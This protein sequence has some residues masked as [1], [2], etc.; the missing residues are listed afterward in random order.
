MAPLKLRRIDLTANNAAAQITKL[1]DQFRYDSEVVSAAGKKLT[2]GVFGEAL[3]PVRAVERICSD[4]RDKGLPAV[5]SYTEQFDKVKLK[6]DALRVK[7]AELAEAHAAASPEFLEAIRQVKYNVEQFQ[8]GVL[9][10]DAVMRVSERHELQLRYRPLDRVGVYCPGGAAAYPSTLLMTVCPAQAAGVEQIIVCM[11]PKDT[12]AYSREMLATCHELG[13]KEVY[14]VGGAQA[15]AAM[16]YGVD[17]LAPVDMIVGPGN[18]YV[19]LAKKHVFGQVAIDCIAGPS[20][21]VVAADD[22]AHPDWV[23]LDMIAQAEHSPGVAI[24]VTWYEPL[25][26]EVQESITKKLAK[27]SRADLARDSLERFGAL[28]LAP[29]KKAALD[30]VNALAPEHLH[31]QTR[32]PEAF[33]EQVRNAGAV[34]L[35]PF[36]PVAVGDYAAGPSHVLPT[37]GTARWA[38]GLNANDFR[39]RTSIMRFTRNGLKEIAP[40]V[41][42]LA[43]TEGLTAHAASV[44][45]RANNN[46]PEARPKPKVDKVPAAAA[47]AA[48][49]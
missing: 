23:A 17:G 2:V 3:S 27:L 45:I 20:E 12:G 8:S 40:D 24:L 29:D 19:A 6:P 10:R 43:N 31:V 42:Y 28:V 15:I 46:G 11:P 22:A 38:S 36:T 35:G 4:V 26:N 39:K 47:A 49:K 25:V 9:H 30:C 48:K 7:P 21:V 13:I 16:A 44:E 14:R 32:D 34:F 41:I 1:R 37:G 18:Q 33:V 5:L